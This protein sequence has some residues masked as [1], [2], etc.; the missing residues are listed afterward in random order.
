MPRPVEMGKIN[1]RCQR[2]ADLEGDDHIDPEEWLE[3]ID[4][5]YGELFSIVA[6]TGTRYFERVASLVTV[7]TNVLDEPAS[8]MSTIGLWYVAPSGKKT[9]LVPI[10]PH[11]L[12]QY[13]GREGPSATR[14]E[15]VDGFLYLYPTPPAGQ[16]YE[17]RYLPQSPDLSG[18]ASDQ[19]VDVV[20]AEGL[21]FLV[22]AVVVKAKAKSE[23]DVRLATVERDIAAKKV[24][25][26]ATY[27]ALTEAPRRMVT[28][29]GGTSEVD[30]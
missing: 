5:A 13:S 9:R 12:E 18:Y 25:D 15:L 2:R 30:E 21:S 8:V 17:L 26:W 7:G 1:G 4:E 11:E 24:Q 22:W 20:I 14:Y 16:T 3:L 19:C 6:D 29:V 28:D 10:M 27:R 23:K